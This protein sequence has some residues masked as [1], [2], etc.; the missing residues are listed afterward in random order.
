MSVFVRHMYITSIQNE[1]FTSNKNAIKM[2]T[3]RC[4]DKTTF[5][6]TD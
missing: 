3:I 1:K 4:G 5:S 6:Y 2:Y